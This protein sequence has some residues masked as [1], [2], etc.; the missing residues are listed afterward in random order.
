[1]R[2]MLVENARPTADIDPSGVR[3]QLK[4]K[5][6]AFCDPS[7]VVLM[8]SKAGGSR[9]QVGPCSTDR[10]KEGATPLGSNGDPANYATKIGPRWGPAMMRRREAFKASHISFVPYT[11]CTQSVLE[12]QRYEID[13]CRECPTNRRY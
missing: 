4:I 11:V 9:P 13:A 3:Y 2:S 10:E 8:G 12:K 5:P 1:M 6:T 7:G